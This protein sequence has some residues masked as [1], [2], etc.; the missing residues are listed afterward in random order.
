LVAAPHTSNPGTLPC[1]PFRHSGLPFWDECGPVQFSGHGGSVSMFANSGGPMTSILPD[2]NG[3]LTVRC[4]GSLG[5]AVGRVV[6]E[7]PTALNGHDRCSNPRGAR[8]QGQPNPQI[9]SRRRRWTHTSEIG[10]V[11]W[12]WS[13][14]YAQSP[15]Y[16]TV[17]EGAHMVTRCV[18][19]N[20]LD[21]VHAFGPFLG[22]CPEPP[23]S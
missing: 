15:I 6:G 1:W 2:R 11:S 10:P 17:Q 8:S 16:N 12:S 19:A 13:E 3:S 14:C 9:P 23:G 20:E 18:A 22:S 7:N 21:D 5:R 4:N